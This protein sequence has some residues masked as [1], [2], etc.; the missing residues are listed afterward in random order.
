MISDTISNLTQSV[1]ASN[2]SIEM[3]SSMFT[4]LTKNVYNNVILAPIREWSTNAIDACHA[5]N[6][7]THFDVHL[8]TISN[9]TFSVRDY[10]TGLP[11]EDVFGLFSTAGAST[12]RNSNKYNGS[13][14]IG[15]LSGL[16]YATSFTV[17]SFY[18]NTQYS[19]M[20][21]IDNGIPVTIEL[22]SN[23]TTEPNGLRLSLSVKPEDAN[24]FISEALDLY[25]HF[26]HK[27]NLLSNHEI[28]KLEKELEGKDWFTIK[29]NH[30]GIKLLMANVVYEVKSYTY[31]FP[32]GTVIKAPTGSVS[33]TPGRESLNYDDK[34]DTFLK[35][36][37]KK[38]YS[39][40]QE[41]AQE[42]IDNQ[43]TPVDRYNKAYSYVEAFSHKVT[44]VN[45][46]DNHWSSMLT[47]YGYSLLSF[48][49][50]D[51]YKVTSYT[52]SKQQTESNYYRG[53]LP[54]I[55][56]CNL[57]KNISPSL[58][59][60]P[61]NTKVLILKPLSNSKVSLQD[62]EATVYDYLDSIGAEYD[63]LSDYLVETETSSKSIG[64]T[65]S[66]FQP[67][68]Y[69][70]YSASYYKGSILS[71]DT[72]KEYLYL[73]NGADYETEIQPAIQ[74]VRTISEISDKAASSLIVIPKKVQKLVEA[75]PA[76]TLAT[77]YISEQLDSLPEVKLAHGHFEIYYTSEDYPEDVQQYHKIYND[78][79]ALDMPKIGYDRLEYLKTIKPDIKYREIDFNGLESIFT[80]YP[81]LEHHHGQSLDLF[82]HYMKLERF[83]HENNRPS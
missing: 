14:G 8:P 25:K 75:N 81:Y 52:G 60:Y 21:S 54:K 46:F 45:N 77:D 53:K 56:V 7:P 12:K 9:P 15:R 55:L 10:G 62:F 11:P 49:I 13:F 23:P 48:I 74:A 32:S 51:I 33:I 68:I 69:R 44:P 47:K 5:A 37:S 82:N 27:P 35:E 43:L 1:D 36:T 72:T 66:T 73:V 58:N 24:K 71:T 29:N 50:P 28:P 39:E 34:T 40:I 61:D 31:N 59:N 16:A 3:N 64:L 65:K 26:E 76:F 6:K 42:D 17:E 70:T 80:K 30:Y 57:I 18:N 38:I 2:F 78:F 79:K 41:K 83:Y 67:L 20:I 19:Y 4:M 22:G 63:K